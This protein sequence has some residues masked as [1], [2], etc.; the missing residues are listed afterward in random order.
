MVRMVAA[1]VFLALSASWAV[2]GGCWPCYRAWYPACAYAS[3]YPVA[4][5]AYEPYGVIYNRPAC[6]GYP[7]ISARRARAI[8]ALFPPPP[9]R[10]RLDLLTGAIALQGGW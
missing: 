2:A 7:V 3:C 6:A 8:A 5:L 1:V 10:Y 9:P 4:G